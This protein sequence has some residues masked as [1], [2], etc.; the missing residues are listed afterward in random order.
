MFLYPKPIVAALNG[1]T[2]AAGCMLAL[3]C[4]R[5]VMVTGNAKIS[6][7][8]VSFGSS[9]FV[10]STEI[11]RFWVGSKNAT[12]ILYSG[13]MYSAEEA[14]GLFLIED[15]ASEQDVISVAA[16]AASELGAK[17]SPAFASIKRLLWKRAVENAR[18]REV[19]SIGEFVEIWYSKA[20]WANLGKIKIYQ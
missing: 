6:L 4:D 19:E 14:Q 1:H 11:L 15:V 16:K 18:R 7:N 9:I 2:I 20:T 13:A 17:N 5:R 3:A 10:G 8:E 12:E